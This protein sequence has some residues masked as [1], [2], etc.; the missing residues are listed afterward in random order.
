MT[1]LISGGTGL[2]GTALTAKL[3]DRNHRVKLL[4]RDNPIDNDQFLWNTEEGLIDESAFDDVQSIIHLAGATI[5]KR[6]TN[7]YKKIII[8][9]REN[10]ANLL[11][12]SAKRLNLRL[13]S[14]ISAS[15]VNFY[16]TITT[17]KILHEQSPI[18]SQDFLSEV[19][20]K[21][22]AAAWQFEGVSD[23]VVILRTAPVLS[24]R[25][26]AFEP[27]KKLSDYNLAA[28]VG[29]GEQWFN[30]IHLDDLVNMYVT[31]IE[32]D[33]LKGAYNAVADQIPT[34]RDFMRRLAHANN[35][36]FIPMNIPSFILKL[37]MGEMSEM[38]LKG[39]RLSNQKIKSHGLSLKYPT[40]ESAFED[41]LH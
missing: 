34:N 6:W 13:N 14:F 2:V 30:W 21:W 1:I 5:A 33:E 25:G 8:N 24:K 12:N 16:G 40:V 27:L 22:E 35:K 18:L 36:I 15:G 4:V 38:I 11:L 29:S 9:S 20:A 31:A 23:R 26:G 41:L 3:R 37:A 17:D 32:N 28:G 7:K 39:T 19:C 10:T